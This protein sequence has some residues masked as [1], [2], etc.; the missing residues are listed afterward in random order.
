LN[1]DQRKTLMEEFQGTYEMPDRSA[2]A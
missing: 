2:E 1:A